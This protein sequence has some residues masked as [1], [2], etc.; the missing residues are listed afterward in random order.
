MSTIDPAPP[1]GDG[2]RR[3]M[4]F[5]EQSARLL[6]HAALVGSIY[7]LFSGHNQPGGGFVG[8]LVAGSAITLRYLAGGIDAVRGISRFQP[9]TILG[10]GVAIAA[11]TALL[12]LLRGE[13]VMTALAW[14]LDLPALGHLRPSTTLAF[15]IGVYFA[16]VGLVFMVF[17]AFADEQAT[18]ADLVARAERDARE[19]REQEST[20]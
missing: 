17:E 1:P 12:P 14:D 4:P 7:L 15:D 2:W 3:P 9:W 16:V 11:A 20:S 6:F 8:G 19:Q 10:A 13:P 5:L 18:A